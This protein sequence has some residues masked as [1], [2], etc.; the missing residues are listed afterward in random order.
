MRR[1]KKAFEKQRIQH[2]LQQKQQA[3]YVSKL[4]MQGK[5]GRK[6]SKKVTLHHLT[7]ILRED[8]RESLVHFLK[9]LPIDVLVLE[10][11]EQSASITKYTQLMHGFVNS[12]PRGGVCRPLA[13]GGDP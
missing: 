10:V 3:F 7:V 1:A 8:Q 6:S 2:N 9:S 12:F 5:T 4:Q 11:S 13:K